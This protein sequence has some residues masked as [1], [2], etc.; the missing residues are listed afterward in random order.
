MRFL[1]LSLADS[2][3]DLCSCLSSAAL[4]TILQRGRAAG[5]CSRSS[6][7]PGGQ[8]RESFSAFLSAH[9]PVRPPYEASWRSVGITDWR[10]SWNASVT[11]KEV[12]SDFESEEVESASATQCALDIDL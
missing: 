6:R 5:G 12:S 1:L 11:A 8:L 10:Q 9:V 7:R 4:G 2:G 3:L